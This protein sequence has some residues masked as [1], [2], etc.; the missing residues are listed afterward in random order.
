MR[1]G[2]PIELQPLSVRGPVFPPRPPTVCPF[3]S[4]YRPGIGLDKRRVRK[5][6]AI[7]RG[8]KSG[9]RLLSEQNVVD[10]PWWHPGLGGIRLA[11][12]ARKGR[13]LRAATP[14]TGRVP[15]GVRGR[16]RDRRATR[17]APAYRAPPDA[18]ARSSLQSRSR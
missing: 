18:V 6:D 14:A 12:R 7:A 3:R 13:Q 1:F 17:R 2:T 8:S 4:P 11:G 9:E 5:L 10:S 16:R 15:G